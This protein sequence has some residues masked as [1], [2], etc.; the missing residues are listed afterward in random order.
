[1]LQKEAKIKKGDKIGLVFFPSTDV[2]IAFWG[3]LL[4][5]AVPIALPP[6]LRLAAD[7]PTFSAILD[8]VDAK[9]VLS[10]RSYQSVSSKLAI[11]LRL[12]V[13]FILFYFILFLRPCHHVFSTTKSLSPKTTL[14]LCTK[15]PCS[16]SSFFG[17]ERKKGGTFAHN[18][19]VVLGLKDLVVEK[20]WLQDRRRFYFILFY[21]ILFYFILFYFILF[22][23]ILFYFI[24]FY[25][26]IFYF[27]F[28]LI[29]FS[30]LRGYF[31]GLENQLDGHQF[32]GCTLMMLSL[33]LLL[34][35]PP[36]LLWSVK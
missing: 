16:L 11:Q 33:L 15:E 7:L 23:F 24:L 14:K 12:Q 17:F 21:F 25:F 1:M 22:Y 2:L 18:L 27:V 3:C 30:S 35:L 32:L 29:L 28:I 13:Y 10:H 9:V 36:F 31:L 26:M 20:T 4:L 5:G 34:P 8:K 19:R 6:P